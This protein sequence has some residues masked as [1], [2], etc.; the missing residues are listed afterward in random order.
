M[1]SRREGH[2]VSAP[3]DATPEAAQGGVLPLPIAS[4]AIPGWLPDAEKDVCMPAASGVGAVGAVGAAGAGTASSQLI[5]NV[6]L[7]PITAVHVSFMVGQMV[8]RVFHQ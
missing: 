1:A 4:Q 8:L 5:P 3:F 2:E 6:N 7:T